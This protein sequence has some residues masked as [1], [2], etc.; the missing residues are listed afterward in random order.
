MLWWRATEGYGQEYATDRA[1]VNVPWSRE[2]AHVYLEHRDP[3]GAAGQLTTRAVWRHSREWGE[4][5]EAEP[6]WNPGREA[7]FVCVVVAME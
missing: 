2:R 4:W 7:V 3:V 1:Q 5:A 6:D